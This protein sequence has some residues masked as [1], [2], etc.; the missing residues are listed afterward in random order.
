MKPTAYK[1]SWQVYTTNDLYH[2]GM[3]ARTG[4]RWV[5]HGPRGDDAGV[6]ESAQA[7]VDKAMAAA[8]L[9]ADPRELRD[10]AR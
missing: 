6:E 9:L 1:A 7:A 2:H 4:W 10:G 8:T 5:A 3:A